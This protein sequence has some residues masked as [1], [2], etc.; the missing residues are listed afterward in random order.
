M[1]VIN[2]HFLD[3]VV[4]QVNQTAFIEHDPISVPHL[5]TAKEDREIAG[6]LS[7]VL[8][9]GQRLVTIR[10]AKKLIERMDLAP[11]DFVI[12]HNRNELKPFQDFAHRT[13]NGVDTVYFITSLKNIYLRL[14]GLEKIFTSA[15]DE[16]EDSGIPIHRFRKVFF[17]LKHEKR[18]EKHLAD[19]L[20]GSA[21]KRVNMF[22]R[23]MIRKDNQG[24]DFGIW[25]NI[26]ASKLVCPLDVHSARNARQWGLLQRRQNDWEAAVELT[27]MLKT[28]DPVDPV[29]Y[30]FALF[31]FSSTKLPG[32]H[33]RESLT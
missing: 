30:D 9:W 1:P 21:A 2:R 26:P 8:A 3:F 18:T 12:N 13:F 4:R 28:F 5:F 25:K 24:V 20:S 19:P 23:W 10:N 15:F 16:S 11:Y 6:F 7:A 29:K 31:G 17:S 33:F 32:L 22:L 14:G 27:H